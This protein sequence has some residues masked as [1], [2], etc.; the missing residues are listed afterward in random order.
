MYKTRISY[1]KILGVI[2]PQCNRQ[3]HLRSAVTGKGNTMQM[4]LF[5]CA[6][7]SLV[8][9]RHEDYRMPVFLLSFPSSNLLLEARR[10]RKEGRTY[11]ESVFFV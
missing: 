7:L 11:Y 9:Q 8:G 10:V 2:F 3:F 5:L 1:L 6:G 4:Y